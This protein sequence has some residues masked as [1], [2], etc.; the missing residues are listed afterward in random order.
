MVEDLAERLIE[1]SDKQKGW[2]RDLLR[3]IA[4][5]EIFDAN[6]LREYAEF[7]VSDK[8]DSCQGWFIKPPASSAMNLQPLQ[9]THLTKID[10][11]AEPVK[12]KRIEHL[13][14]A[15]HL[16]PGTT[17]E[18]AAIGLNIVAGSNGSG[19]SGYTRIIKQIAASRAPGTVL[20]NVYEEPI[21]PSAVVTYSAGDAEHRSF[22]WTSSNCESNDELRRIRV[23]DTA[24]AQNHLGRSSEVAYVPPALQIMSDYVSILNEISKLIEGWLAEEKASETDF[25][26]L[27]QGPDDSV[28]GSLGTKPAVKLISELECPNPEQKKRVEE[29]PALIFSLTQN[30]PAKLAVQASERS[31][32]LI[33]LK[34]TLEKVSQNIT[35]QTLTKITNLLA[36][37]KKAQ[38]KVDAAANILKNDPKMTAGTGNGTWR[39]LWEA[40]RVHVAAS[41]EDVELSSHLHSCPLCQQELN[42]EAKD[43]FDK[44]QTFLNAEAQDSLK[45]TEDELENAIVAIQN[46]VLPVKDEAESLTQ[47]TGA[48]C[49][50][51]SRSLEKTLNI[52]SS[53]REWLIS[54]DDVIYSEIPSEVPSNESA[55]QEVYAD[56]TEIC[57]KLDQFS[58]EET[59]SAN[60][61]RQTDSSADSIIKLKNE[62]DSLTLKDNLFKS[63]DELRGE[64]DRRLREKCLSAAQRET[65]T[66]SATSYNK[67]LS[68]N[69]VDQVCDQFKKEANNLGIDRVPVAL[70]FDK[71]SK[72]VNY[73]RVELEDAPGHGVLDVLSEGEQ[74]VSAIAGFFAD[75]TESGDQSLLIFD[76][77]VSSLDQVFRRKVARRLIRE[78]AQR[79]VIVFTH[80]ITFVQELYEQHE[81]WSRNP[82]LVGEA[83]IVTPHYQHINRTNEGTGVPTESEHWYQVK[84]TSKIGS[85]R[86]RIAASRP[87]YKAHD[88]TKYLHLA[89][90]ISGSI[91]ECWEILV[92]EV[93]LAGV[94]TR[95]KRSVETQK[96]KDLIPVREEDIERVSSGMGVHSRFFRGHAAPADDQAAPPIPDELEELVKEI[97][98][99]RKE[100]IKRREAQQSARKKSRI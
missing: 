49:I 16:A 88:E 19:K 4:E 65:S 28:I 74:R 99:Y 51:I 2:Q 84:L 67:E 30:D 100:I 72:G 71:A 31:R 26:P 7:A 47:F 85:I 5:G 3:R 14:G 46:I 54:R 18:F 61:L 83:E 41:M 92:E 23:F 64:H 17:L 53:V 89:Q 78:A 55:W 98:D 43:R 81:L 93:L 35:A 52:Y 87:I 13:E 82:Q 86:S 20:P 25:S 24:S 70:R 39:R 42:S 44:F 69:Y 32:R 73:I 59:A 48:Y 10:T 15:N 94:V 37:R 38:A 50:E 68:R 27:S 58:A 97:D 62:L 66:R 56:V 40:A 60:K 8:Y 12:L 90:D 63:A 91:R 76:D 36:E 80:D 45:Q 75:L 22:T 33:L 9:L 29:L 34:N 6:S 96:L 95:F 21:E 79:Q 77:P 11:L 1:W 57:S